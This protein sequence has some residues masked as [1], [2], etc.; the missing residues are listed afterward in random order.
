MTVVLV[1]AGGLLGTL[2]RYGLSVWAASLWTIVAVNLAG[3][4]ALGLLVHVGAGWPGEVRTAL[5]VGVLGGFTTYSTFAVQTVL[6]ADGG[7]PGRAAA[8]LLA[9][10]V[11]GLAAA[12]AGYV[13]GRWL[14]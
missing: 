5:G 2:A 14:A 11:G 7:R 3:S 12:V 1:A 13:L 6:E 10:V 4:F 9:T 8:Y